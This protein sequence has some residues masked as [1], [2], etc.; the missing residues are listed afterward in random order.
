MSKRIPVTLNP[1]NPD[2]PVLV[3]GKAGVSLGDGYCEMPTNVKRIGFREY[4][5]NIPPFCYNCN[6]PTEFE[7]CEEQKDR[8][9]Y[10]NLKS[11][12]YMFENDT[13]DRL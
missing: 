11:P 1:K 8:D 5:K 10:P 4:D 6:N 12:D 2:G 13:N 7:C 3:D 9:L